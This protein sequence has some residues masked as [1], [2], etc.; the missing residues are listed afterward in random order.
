MTSKGWSGP[1]PMVAGGLQGS[2]AGCGWRP[3]GRCQS[4]GRRMQ[5]GS[6]KPLLSGMLFRL[7]VG[8]M[9]PG[10]L[11]G[12]PCTA[13]RGEPA[14]TALEEATA[15]RSAGQFDEALEVLR[16]ESREIKRIEGDNSPRLLVV[17]DLAAEIL[18]DQGAIDKATAL[19]EK[20]IAAR[21]LLIKTG[22]VDQ[23]AGLGESLLTQA[24]IDM[25]E[26]RY[27]QAAEACR[28]AVIAFD[29]GAGP[30]TPALDRGRE[31]LGQALTRLDDL[32]GLTAE[33]TREAR[34]QA[35]KTFESLGM[36]SAA[37]EQRRRL[38]DAERA[39]P[40]ASVRDVL[41]ASGRLGTALVAGGQAAEAAT[42]QAR[43]VDEVITPDERGTIAAIEAIRQLG[44]FQAAAESYVLADDS[45]RQVYELN[46][47]AKRD[48]SR[49]G[50]RDRLLGLA[51]AVQA[52]REQELPA[53]FV[54]AVNG[55]SRGAPGEADAGATGLMAAAEI[56]MEL[57]H[58]KEAV[59]LLGRGLAIAQAAKPPSPE[60]IA[61]LAARLVSAQLAIDDVPA[62][63]KTLDKTLAAA[64]AAL[65]P[66]DSGLVALRLAQ[67]DTFARQADTAAARSLASTLLA[68]GLPRPSPTREEKT[69]AVFDR[70]A[71]RC[72]TPDLDL[73]EQFVAARGRQFGVEHPYVAAAWGF[74]GAARL[75]AGDWQKAVECLSLA[76]RIQEQSLGDDHPELAATLLLLGQAQRAAGDDTAAVESLVRS[77]EI[78]RKAVG[79]DHP[80]SMA[81]LEAMAA[82]RAAAK[83]AT[84]AVPLFE[85]LIEAD[86]L[87]DDADPISKANHF[88]RLAEL[89]AGKDKPRSRELLE[90]ADGLPCWT[91][92]TSHGPREIRRLALTAALA[93]HAWTSLGERE[94]SLEQLRR[95]RALAV[96]LGDSRE[97]L[98]AVEQIAA[99]GDVA[100]P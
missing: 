20:T 36:F 90:A 81:A 64:E 97:L 41:G 54:S 31:A 35:A 7:L 84:E 13:A 6:R 47:A 40:A 72:N 42:E 5:F 74:F 79:P 18:V 92:N 46:V 14:S 91:S 37:I 86:A 60:L 59:E 83:Q 44:E 80:G 39:S 34:S 78:W 24:R 87:R 10:T 61:E 38:L 8:V 93:A 94:R 32:L 71:D 1:G 68:R 55:L 98:E 28:R 73:R 82:A 22:R 53:W 100:G 96:E 76:A 75:A 21:E 88:V 25:I 2:A 58:R 70:L 63:R 49:S 51:V 95:G 9:L 26:K 12:T 85:E 48:T 77:L 89:L 23:Q 67:A 17:N 27:P 16:L 15:L 3:L 43:T 52:G 65:G 50:L 66:G 11:A 99:K 45:F 29:A 69:V 30:N 33:A 57:D 19:L 56:Q 4:R 62:A